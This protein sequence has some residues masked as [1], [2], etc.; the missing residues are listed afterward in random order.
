[1]TEP[2]TAGSDS[3]PWNHLVRQCLDGDEDAWSCLV[4]AAW[5][6]VRSWML[7]AC[8]DRHLAEDL[9]QTVF[10]RLLEDEGRRLRAFDPARSAGFPAYLKAI[11]GNL[12]VDWTRSR[13]GLDRTRWY[14]LERVPDLAGRAPSPD[15]EREASRILDCVDRLRPRERQ[16]LR[17][18]LCGWSYEEI[19]RDLKIGSGGTGALIHRGRENL[20]ALLED[21][22]LFETGTSAET[23]RAPRAS[24]TLSPPG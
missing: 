24:P 15:G 19:A 14:D 5:P 13:E 6:L 1:M 2:R 17:L 16:A 9:A 18:L 20:R 4:A 22:P 23:R 10:L 12:H 21:D 8:R 3:V 7:R 11:A